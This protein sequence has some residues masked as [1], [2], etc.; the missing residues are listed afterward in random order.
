[1]KEFYFIRHGQTDHNLKAG[2]KEEQSPDIPLNDNGRGQARSI[3]PL[4]ASLPVKRVCCSPFRRAQETKE[5]ITQR[6]LV[7]HHEIKDLG[8]CTT[9]IWDEMMAFGKGD[10]SEAQEPIRSFFERVQRGLNEALHQEGPVLVVAHGG[11]HWALCLLLNP[12]EHDWIID[13][14]VPVHFTFNGQWQA[15]KLI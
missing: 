1:M 11:I 8:E 3:E 4:I 9:Q 12:T 14:C 2:K 10:I 13:N 15:K 6:L 7:P 5:I